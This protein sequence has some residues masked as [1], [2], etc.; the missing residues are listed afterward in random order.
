MLILLVILFVIVISHNSYDPY[1][2]EGTRV[3]YNVFESNLL[4]HQIKLIYKESDMFFY[5]DIIPVTISIFLFNDSVKIF[6]IVFFIACFLLA[7][8][9]SHLKMKPILYAEKKRQ[10]QELKEELRKEQ[11]L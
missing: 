4:P 7:L 1:N 3:S 6:S 8:F 2:D 11:G 9:Y 5:G 10:D